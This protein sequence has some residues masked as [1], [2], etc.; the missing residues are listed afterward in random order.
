[1]M[2]KDKEIM[3]EN[4]MD[5]PFISE[6]QCN[7]YGELEGEQA[8]KCPIGSYGNYEFPPLCPLS[9]NNFIIKRQTL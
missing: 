8:S 3:V 9:K 4:P 1:M 6:C 7:L 2:C 5:C